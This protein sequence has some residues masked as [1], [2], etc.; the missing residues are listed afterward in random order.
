MI[1]EP[2]VELDLTI[3]EGDQTF[4]L[5]LD[6]MYIIG[7]AGPDYEG[8]Y[9]VRPDPHDAIILPTARKLMLDD[10]TVEKIPYYTTTNL[11]GGYTAIIGD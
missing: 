1:L 10:V 4:D 11:A 9:Q 6:G 2:L 5:A 7:P 8:P 3:D